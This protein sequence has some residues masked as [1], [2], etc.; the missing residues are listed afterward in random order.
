[1]AA[2]ANP[3]V[4]VGVIAAGAVGGILSYGI[5]A[6][7]KGEEMT[8]GAAISA[9]F[10][11][12]V[13][14]ALMLTPFDIVLEAQLALNVVIGQAQACTSAALTS[15]VDGKEASGPAVV[16]DVLLTSAEDAVATVLPVNAPGARPIVQAGAAVAKALIAGSGGAFTEK[17]YRE[18]ERFFRVAI[19]A[20]ERCANAGIAEGEMPTS[21]MDDDGVIRPGPRLN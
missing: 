6:F 1:M 12:V 10:W 11:G 20:W 14:G 4:A 16:N 18:G 19:E 17:A 21:H 5:Q 15:L 9:G 2:T 13:Q 3:M 8:W 7:T